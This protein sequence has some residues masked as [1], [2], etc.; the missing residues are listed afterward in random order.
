MIYGVLGRLSLSDERLKQNIKIIENPIDKVKKLRGVE[1]EWNDKQN[2]YESNSLDAG[3]IGQDVEKV[4]P[5]LVKERDDG[6]LGVRHDRLVGLL[7]EAI[8]DPQDGG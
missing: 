2:T 3:I 5:Q 4:L 6:H 7:I 8:K 1:Y